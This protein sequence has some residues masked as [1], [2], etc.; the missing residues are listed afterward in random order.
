MIEVLLL[1]AEFGW[2]LSICFFIKF[3]SLIFS[4][5]SLCS[6]VRHKFRY[7]RL[8]S[9]HDAHKAGLTEDLNGISII[10]E[11]QTVAAKLKYLLIKIIKLCQQMQ[12]KLVKQHSPVTS[13][14]PS[15]ELE[16]S[17]TFFCNVFNSLV[18]AMIFR[19]RKKFGVTM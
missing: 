11:Y 2:V 17:L 19:T 9:K 16:A 14:V 13:V 10:E 12:N 3:S 1:S 5:S 18:T 4:C 8:Q 15:V 7:E 6:A